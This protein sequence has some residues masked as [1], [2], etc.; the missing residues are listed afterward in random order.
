MKLVYSAPIAATAHHAKNILE[1]HG[2]DCVLKG[3]FLSGAIGE[4]PPH[5][6]WVELWVLDE[7]R[8]DE[9]Q[10]IINETLIADSGKSDPRNCPNCGAEIDGPF[11]QCWNCGADLAPVPE[12]PG[13]A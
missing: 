9:A 1:S 5:E 11:S 7:S 2:I 3:E 4:I 6:A 10:K 13:Q 8:Y 12:S